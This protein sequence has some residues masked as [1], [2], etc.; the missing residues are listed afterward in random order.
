MEDL[1][2]EYLVEDVHQQDLSEYLVD[3]VHQQLLA[4]VLVVQFETGSWTAEPWYLTFL[5]LPCFKFGLIY[6]LL[7]YIQEWM[8]MEEWIYLVIDP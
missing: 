4:P 8:M 2:E 3:V 1:P 6:P 7:G 5:H